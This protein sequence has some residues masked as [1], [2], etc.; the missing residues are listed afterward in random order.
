MFQVCEIKGIVLQYK[1]SN[2]SQ[3]DSLNSLSINLKMGKEV[4]SLVASEI[5]LL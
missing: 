1:S 4:F 3:I 2:E 5:Q